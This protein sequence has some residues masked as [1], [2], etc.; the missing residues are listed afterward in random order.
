MGV[1]LADPIRRFASGLGVREGEEAP[2][3]GTGRHWQTLAN[4]GQALTGSDGLGR[5][6]S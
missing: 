1:E 6:G 3:A 2:Q 4:A 5:P